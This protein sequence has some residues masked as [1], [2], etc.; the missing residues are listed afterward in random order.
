VHGM[1]IVIV[2]TTDKDDE[3]LALLREMGVP[4]RGQTPV[5]VSSAAA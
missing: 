2:T 5:Q 3:A 4:F 1:D